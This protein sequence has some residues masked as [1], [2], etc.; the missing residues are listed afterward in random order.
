MKSDP[1]LDK[2]IE[3]LD[4]RRNLIHA[5]WQREEPEK[6]L[7][8]SNTMLGPANKIRAFDSHGNAGKSRPYHIRHIA[9]DAPGLPD[10]WVNKEAK[11]KNSKRDQQDPL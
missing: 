9:L 11:N 5:Y 2:R 7:G 8:I 3:S 4:I 1:L 10:L 6:P